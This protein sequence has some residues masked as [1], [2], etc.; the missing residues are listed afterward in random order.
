MMPDIFPE[1]KIWQMP[2]Q[3]YCIVELLQFSQIPLAKNVISS[4]LNPLI[5][6]C[7]IA[8]SVLQVVCL[9]ALQ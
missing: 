5:L 6:F 3:C 4:I 8:I 9:Q 2:M 1:T 7:G